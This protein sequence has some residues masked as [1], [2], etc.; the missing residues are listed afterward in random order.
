MD[1]ES[2]KGKVAVVTGAARG[3]GAAIAE[4]LARDGA[5]VVVNYSKSEKDADAVVDRI[6]KA[7]GRAS[8]HKADMSDPAQAKALIE[9]A[10][11][12]HRRL[13]ILVNNAGVANFAPLEAIDADHV[14]AHFD[15]NVTG[16]IF[17]TQAAAAHLPKEG[18]RV[19]N[20]GSSISTAALPGASVYAATK[21]ALDALTR[22]WAM[23]LGP[24]GVTVNSVAPGPI[25][26]DMFKAVI[27]AD[28][29]QYLVSRTPLGRIGLPDDVAGLVAFLASSDGRWVTGE[30]IAVNGGF[31]P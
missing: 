18:G 31:N 20:V 27:N 21:A 8:A 7:G 15:L 1:K 14:R 5:T 6:R 2:L 13:D 28:M 29:A 30:V 24:K 22:V 3:I 11:K 4:R 9:A 12:E 10:F 23:E 26:T 17:A 16:L 19:I 25:E